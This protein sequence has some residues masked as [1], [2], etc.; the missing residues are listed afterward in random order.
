MA[1]GQDFCRSARRHFRAA[2]EL[3]AIASSGAQPGCKAVAG[4]LFGL[5]GELAVKEMMRE[6]GMSPLPPEQRRDD[7]YFAHFP[8][9]KDRLK[10]HV[11]GRRSGELRRIAES[12]S[13][14][15]HWNTDMRY[16]PTS[17]ILD[18]WID[19]WSAS[20]KSLLEQMDTP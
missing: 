12:A 5:A 7:P 11:A 3:Y 18:A 13:L 16:A 19:A 9:L 17:D 6:S 8:Y 4:Y 15:Q 14:F 20:A 2:Q 10:D 1:Y